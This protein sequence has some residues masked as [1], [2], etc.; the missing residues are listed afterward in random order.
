MI[1]VAICDDEELYRERI[2]KCISKDFF[3]EEFSSG[4][5]FLEENDRKKFDIVIL[6]ID[7]PELKGVEVAE[8]LRQKPWKQIVI[9]ATNYDDYASRAFRLGVYR[10]VIKN[11]LE[12]EIAEALNSAVR[13]INKNDTI[14]AIKVKDVVHRIS[15][16]ELLY[17]EKSGRVIKLHLWD[18]RGNFEIKISMRDLEEQ[19]EPYGFV[20]VHIGCLVNIQNIM[21]EQNGRFIMDNGAEIPIARDR[22]K[23]VLQKYKEFF[24]KA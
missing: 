2:K 6:D 16:R 21:Q 14:C 9:F 10:Y 18:G 17:A 24:W 15:L 12:E 5:A 4:I 7:M 13:E 22:K 19:L 23:A 8:R 1:R 3:V 20:R 11:N